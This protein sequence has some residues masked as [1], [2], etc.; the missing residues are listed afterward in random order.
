MLT[1][2]KGISASCRRKTRAPRTT[3]VVRVTIC[4]TN[5]LLGNKKKPTRILEDLLLMVWAYIQQ[6]IQAAQALY[7]MLGR[8]NSDP[9]IK[10]ELLLP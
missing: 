9:S 5:F 8:N 2:V 7:L 4:S 6:M 10:S 1:E 3:V